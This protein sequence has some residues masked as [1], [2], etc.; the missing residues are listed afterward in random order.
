MRFSQ[1]ARSVSFL[2]TAMALRHA[3]MIPHQGAP[4]LIQEEAVMAS[5]LII[6]DQPYTQEFFLQELIDEGYGVV[7]AGDAKSVK[8]YLEN[9]RP[10]LV[11]LDLYLNGFEG[12]DV[13]HDIKSKDPHLPVLIVTAYDTYADD[14]RV[15]QADGY[16][17]KSFVHLD[18][19]KQKIANVLGQKQVG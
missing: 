10:D 4:R 8:A 15:S 6:D 18:K 13:L 9:S 11:L 2:Q 5:I 17:V 1:N 12:W 19:L 16:V 14:P 7:S 3:Q